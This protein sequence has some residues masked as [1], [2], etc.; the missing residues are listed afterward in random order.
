MPQVLVNIALPLPIVVSDRLI[1]GLG[2]LIL[3]IVVRPQQDMSKNNIQ[4]NA[5]VLQRQAFS[6]KTNSL[7]HG[8]LIKDGNDVFKK[9]NYTLV[10]T[11]REIS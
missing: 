3:P 9:I 6:S 4:Y 7:H 2:K 8:L 1:S 5:V 10:G 11:R